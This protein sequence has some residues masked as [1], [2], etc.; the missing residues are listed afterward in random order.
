MAIARM[1]PGVWAILWACFLGSSL[2]MPAYAVTPPLPRA[3]PL[4]GN[5]AL[6]PENQ[7]GS[8]PE[9]TANLQK[10]FTLEGFFAGETI[11]RGTIFSKIAGAGRSFQVTTSGSWDGKIL[12]LIET[13]HY[14]AGDPDQR[15]WHFTKIADGVYQG[16]STEALEDV[17]LTIE[18]RVASFKYKK[19]LN[20]PAKGPVKVVFNERWTLLEN[21]VLESRTDLKKPFRVGREAINF[22]RLGNEAALKA[23][24]F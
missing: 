19:K 10:K 21:G 7:P 23:P 9:A 12:T 2:A 24:G 17:E 20:R 16:E 5:A 6:V 4:V 18:G 1:K 3:N 8:A 22:V 14:A 15:I 13:Y 11:G